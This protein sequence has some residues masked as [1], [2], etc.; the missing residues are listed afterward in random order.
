VLAL[1]V[2]VGI[3]W[4]PVVALQIQLR[5]AAVAARSV[6]ELDAR[7]HRRFRTWFVLGWPAFVGVMGL[8]GLMLT[9][10][11]FR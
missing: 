6:A 9:R 11:H 7:F 2:F 10:S 8:F 5:D 1:Y 4:L 3:C